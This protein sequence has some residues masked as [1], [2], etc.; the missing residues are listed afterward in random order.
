MGDASSTRKMAFKKDL[1]IW[2]A[3][4]HFLTA[5]L[6]REYCFVLTDAVS[7]GQT[8]LT[9]LFDEQVAEGAP[10]LDGWVVSPRDVKGPIARYLQSRVRHI[11]WANDNEAYLDPQ[12]KD[13]A[14]GLAPRWVENALL[15]GKS[16]AA[17]I[18]KDGDAARFPEGDSINGLMGALNAAVARA[19]ASDAEQCLQNASKFTASFDMPARVVVLKHVGDVLADDDRWSHALSFYRQCER[20]LREEKCTEGFNDYLSLFGNLVTQSIA[21]ALR[22]VEGPEKSAAYL[23]PALASKPLSENLLL[24]MNADHDAFVTS[25]MSE[26]GFNV[27]HDARASLC[28]APLSIA[29]LDLAQAFQDLNAGE[30]NAA[31]RRFWAVLR[32]QLALGSASEA[33]V[34]MAF[35]GRALLNHLE[36]TIDKRPDGATFLQS[37]KLILQSGQP[38][39]A[40]KQE[41]DEKIVDAYVTREMFSEAEAYILRSP[42][43]GKER[44]RTA[45]E[46]VRGW[47]QALPPKETDRAAVLIRFLAVQAQNNESS[48]YGHQNVG[49][50]SLEIIRM[51]AEKRPEFRRA[52]ANAVV[53][54]IL[55]RLRGG[56]FWT[57]ISEA[58]QTADAYAEVLDESDLRRLIAATL[59]LLKDVDPT[60]EVWVV[61]QPAIDFLAGDCVRTIAKKDPVVERDLTAVILRFG[62]QQSTEHARLLFQ[63]FQ[64]GIRSLPDKDMMVQL[65]SA[66]ADVRKKALNVNA[67]NAMAN[68]KA[69]LLAAWAA[70]APGVKDALEALRQAIEGAT[71]DRRRVP[72]AFPYAYDVFILLAQHQQQ[73]AADIGVDLKEFQAWLQ[74]FVDSIVSVWAKAESDPSIFANF[75]LMPGNAPSAVVVHNWAYAS[76]AFAKSLGVYERMS[77]VLERASKRS[78]LTDAIATGRAVRIGQGELRDLR[79]DTIL[80]ESADVFYAALGQR[81]VSLKFLSDGERAEVVRALLEPDGRR[82]S[83]ALFPPP[84]AEAMNRRARR[85]RCRQRAFHVERPYGSRHSSYMPL[86]F[87]SETMSR[88]GCRLATLSIRLRSWIILLN[89]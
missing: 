55:A 17:G 2:T 25:S 71:G 83:K 34:T 9:D 54:A 60:R 51:L 22:C 84:F 75:S 11:V 10:G 23:G 70:K 21:S 86:I 56:E 1:L 87:V 85:P 4:N 5:E 15:L 8:S 14:I 30:L 37:I 59:A 78:E 50:R 36:N 35:Y 44:L 77:A 49:G 6:L 74:P 69:L 80:T 58:F 64:F 43:S 61:V 7:G 48:F 57:G 38:A 27:V 79:P 88:P 73:I 33:R 24:H 31:L 41:W 42:T 52:S 46:L 67:S 63:L 12:K 82:S 18:V 68:I 3:L 72:I 32:R 13:D 39:I 65:D 19:T 53:P 29:S 28:L 81:L 16:D 89:A 20:L 40:E 66:V 45:I 26:N 47:C 62:L 76:L